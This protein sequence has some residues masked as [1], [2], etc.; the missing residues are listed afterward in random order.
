MQS[1]FS[2]S[3]THQPSWENNSY[4]LL[5]F[6]QSVF[7]ILLS[8][9]Q[10]A[11]LGHYMF[12][13]CYVNILTLPQITVLHR[14]TIDHRKSMNPLSHLVFIKDWLDWSYCIRSMN[15]LIWSFKPCLKWKRYSGL[16]EMSFL[17]SI[18]VSNTYILIIIK[19][20]PENRT[21][22]RIHELH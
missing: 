2:H 15:T 21:A 10:I 11:H 5:H 6:S 17:Y 19:T 16:T 20:L 7:V 13:R 8:V 4:L 1:S 12:I 3:K 18:L 22:I 9:T 14:Q